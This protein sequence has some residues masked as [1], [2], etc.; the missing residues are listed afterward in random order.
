MGNRPLKRLESHLENWKTARMLPVSARKPKKRNFPTWRPH[1]KKPSSEPSWPSATVVLWREQ[2]LRS[3]LKS[4]CGRKNSRR[5]R[6]SLSR[7]TTS[8]THPKPTSPHAVANQQH[9]STPPSPPEVAK[10][11]APEP[12]AAPEPEAAPEPA[13]AP[14]PEPEPEPTPEPEPEPEAEPEPAPAPAPVL[15]RPPESDDEESEDAEEEESE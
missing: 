4:P 15:T 2:L 12:A 9:H 13:A 10:V 6:M 14:A 3:L 11:S 5:L 7:W 8:P 1:P